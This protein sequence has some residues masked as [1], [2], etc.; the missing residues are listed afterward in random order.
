MTVAQVGWASCCALGPKVHSGF[1]VFIFLFFFS[2]LFFCFLFNLQLLMNLVLVTQTLH[3][4]T[5]QYYRVHNK[6][7]KFW[8]CLNICFEIKWL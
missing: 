2:F 8:K 7:H 3:I 6:F 4:N 1:S 5:M